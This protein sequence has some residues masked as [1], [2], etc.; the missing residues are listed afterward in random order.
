MRLKPGFESAKT[1][2]KIY[3]AALNRSLREMENW[4]RGDDLQPLL[5]HLAEHCFKA[6]ILEE[7]AMRQVLIHYYS[8]ED[9]LLIRSVFHNLY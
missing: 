6:G 5:V 2:T 1:F 3:E 9:T 4:K 8:E 7:E